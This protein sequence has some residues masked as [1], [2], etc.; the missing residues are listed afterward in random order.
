MSYRPT[1]RERLEDAKRYRG[2]AI[3]AAIVLLTAGWALWWQY[4][5]SG[6]GPVTAGSARQIGPAAQAKAGEVARLEDEYRQALAA[7]AGEDRVEPLLGKLI[8]AQQ[9]LLRLEPRLGAGEAV[10]LGQWEAARSALRSRAAAKKSADLEAEAKA[11]EARGESAAAAAKLRDALQWQREANSQAPTS[12]LK[13]MNREIR[14]AAAVALT[15][16]EPL[17]AAVAAAMAD[18]AAA[19]AAG[20]Q[21]EA[22]LAFRKAR[23]LQAEIN[24]KH[25]GGR[26]ADTALLERIDGELETLRAADLVQEMKAK[27][28][29]ADADAAAGRAEPAAAAYTQAMELQ[30]KLNSAYPRSRYATP[31]RIELLL[32][33]RETALSAA[34]WTAL[35]AL[36]REIALRLQLRQ[37]APAAERIAEAMELLRKTAGAYPRSTLADP[38]LQKRLEFLAVRRGDLAALQGFV[39]ARVAPIPGFP[40]RLMLKT[41]VPQEFF[42]RVMNSNP[43]RHEGRRLPVD[44]VGWAEAQEFCE[45]LGWAL[46]TKVRLPRELEFKA[47]A[48]VAPASVWTQA[49]ADNRSQEAGAA[50]ANAAGFHDLHGNLAEWLEPAPDAPQVSAPLGGGSFLEPE[51]KVRELPVVTVNRRERARHIGFRFVVELPGP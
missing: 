3:A 50:P 35:A 51:A 36:E 30:R 1:W 20:R 32:V 9:E 39:Y 27:E 25:S 13:N 48:A 42:L 37:P 33:K 14:L 11:A 18:G 26:S 12:D 46:G 24:Q 19:A 38:R 7:Q 21:G 29:A 41:E 23:M 47:A 2:P 28:A 8:A 44:S 40:Q 10:R 49:N 43:S 34:G 17:R 22:T 45:R 15:S 31:D 5:R 4:G 6:P 16:A